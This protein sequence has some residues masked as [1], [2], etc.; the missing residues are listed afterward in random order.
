MEPV[1]VGGLTASLFGCVR[2]ITSS[3]K[4]LLDLQI[5]YRQANFT[6]Q[7]FLGHLST[8]RAAF[9]EVDKWI[10]VNL[11]DFLQHEQ[12]V[13]DLTISIEG[14]QVL[15]SILSDRITSLDRNGMDQDGLESL[16]IRGKTRLLWTEAESNQYLSHLNN[17]ISALNLLL[18]A[19]QW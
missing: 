5:R 11:S 12:L 13:S 8:L 7:L 16:S 1:S 2:Y 17:Q 19:F 6:V 15:L 18:T 14:C 3:I 4:S 9:K 10:S